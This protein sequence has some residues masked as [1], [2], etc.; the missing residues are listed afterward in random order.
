MKAF[1]LL[2]LV[3]APAFAQ[4]PA[5][6]VCVRQAI[7]SGFEQWGR[8]VAVRELAPGRFASLKLLPTAAV[9]YAPPPARAPVPGTFGGNFALHVAAAG[10]YRVALSAG[11]W[12]EMVGN[13]KP[14]ASVAHLH[15][16]ACSG[17]GKIVAFAL[18]PGDYVVQLSEAQ[19]RRD[20]GDG[21]G[22]R[23]VGA[24]ARAFR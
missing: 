13:G 18:A 3:A 14:I 10:Q 8:G 11:A 20:H 21:G 23:E 4:A 2:A 6:P 9:A 19:G 1:L 16:P 17:I 5:E 12:I 7:V 15:G 22:G 24:G